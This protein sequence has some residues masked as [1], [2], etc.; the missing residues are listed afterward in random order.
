M[1]Y[2]Y[3]ES[4]A[5]PISESISNDDSEYVALE[6]EAVALVIDENNDSIYVE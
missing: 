4:E 1:R 2:G 3:D 6:V 5:E